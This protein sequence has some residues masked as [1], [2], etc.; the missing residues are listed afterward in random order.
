MQTFRAV[1]INLLKKS[2]VKKPLAR[3]VRV[4]RKDSVR[5]KLANLNLQARD[6]DQAV[7]WARRHAAK[8]G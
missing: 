1:K 4:Q 6:I 8:S 5:T 7:A 3:S 2:G